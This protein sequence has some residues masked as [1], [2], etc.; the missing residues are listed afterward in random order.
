MA[1]GEM[2]VMGRSGDTKI[3]WDRNNADEVAAARAQFDALR[4]KSFLAFSVRR[5]GERGEQINEFDPE[6]EKIILAPQIRG[7]I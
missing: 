3:L 5:N 1:T 4:R 6:A 2:S 7:G